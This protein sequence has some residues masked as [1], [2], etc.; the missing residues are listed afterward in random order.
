MSFRRTILA[1]AP[2]VT[3]TPFV[4]PPMMFRSTRLPLLLPMRPMPKELLTAVLAGFTDPFPLSTFNRTRLL[5]LLV[6]QVPPQGNPAEA[7]F[8]AKKLCEISL[9]VVANSQIPL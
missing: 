9:L 1:L 8:R 6:S 2:A 7:K 3:R 5:L 4:F